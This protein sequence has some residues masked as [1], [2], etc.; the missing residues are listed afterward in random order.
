MKRHLFA[1]AVALIAM[2]G[3][4]RAQTPEA[5][6]A[7][8]PAEPTSATPAAAPAGDTAATFGRAGQIAIMTT[9]DDSDLN[10]HSDVSLVHTSNSMGGSSQSTFSLS[11]TGHYFVIPNVSVSAGLIIQHGD[12]AVTGASG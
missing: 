11:P 6:P 3:T 2:A 8:V 1:A 10:I 7:T 12:V 5:T 4:A 9:L